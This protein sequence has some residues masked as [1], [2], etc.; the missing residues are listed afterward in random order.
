MD[1]RE[2]TQ[3]PRICGPGEPEVWFEDGPGPGS[4]REGPRKDLMQSRF[5]GGTENTH[6]KVID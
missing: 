1:P 4:H 5:G 6:E 3:T 2:V